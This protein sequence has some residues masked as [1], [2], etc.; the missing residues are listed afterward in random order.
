MAQDRF[1]HEVAYS[2]VSKNADGITNNVDPDQ[3]APS[4]CTVKI[5]KIL[6]LKKLL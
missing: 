6:N 1:S 3:T 2:T 5:L 4:R